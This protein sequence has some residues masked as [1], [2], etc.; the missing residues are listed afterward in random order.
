M[1]LSFCH[2]T[3]K[4]YPVDMANWLGPLWVP[5]AFKQLKESSFRE[6]YI[7]LVPCIW[8]PNKSKH[9][10]YICQI[11]REREREG[12]IVSNYCTFDTVQSINF[13][14][15]NTAIEEESY[16]LLF[17]SRTV[18]LFRRKG[19]KKKNNLRV[20]SERSRDPCVSPRAHW[21]NAL[22]CRCTQECTVL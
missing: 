7:H 14:F 16:C 4:H 1:A 8:H 15:L 19:K 9:F 17:L 10:I 12:N 18:K 2:A 13:I 21:S 3:Q 5:T 6:P 11:I 22:S 20:V